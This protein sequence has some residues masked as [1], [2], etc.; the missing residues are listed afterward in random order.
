MKLTKLP[1]L[2]NKNYNYLSYVIGI[3]VVLFFCISLIVPKHE[4]VALQEHPAIEMSAAAKSVLVST[5]NIIVREG[6]IPSDV[7]SKYAILIFEAA[8]KHNVDPLLI[9]S[10]MSV[11]SRFKSDAVSNANAIGLMQVIHFWHKEK[12]TQANLFRPENNINVGTRILAEYTKLSKS[13]TET[14]LRYNGSLGKSNKYAIKVLAKK[15][16]YKNEIMKAIRNT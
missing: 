1:S 10:V 7:A 16:E 4:S 12:T 9:L 2:N 3:V 11:E 8:D 14:L 6:K 13:E 5:K 15:Q